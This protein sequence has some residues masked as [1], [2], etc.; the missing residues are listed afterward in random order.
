M[1]TLNQI[2]TPTELLIKTIESK[3]YLTDICNG[4][5]ENCTSKFNNL[6]NIVTDFIKSDTE[7]SVDDFYLLMTV[8][9]RFGWCIRRKSSTFD[10]KANIYYYSFEITESRNS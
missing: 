8:F 4:I 2:P 3:D 7:L 1:K 9:K 10:A 5:I 6:R